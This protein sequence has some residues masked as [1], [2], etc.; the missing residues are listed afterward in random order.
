MQRSVRFATLLFVLPLVALGLAGTAHAAIM[1][2]TSTVTATWDN[3]TTAN[4]ATVSGG[5]YT[6]AWAS[7]SDAKFEGPAGTV[8]VS[9]TITYVNSIV[10]ATD[11]YLLAGGTVTM[12]GTGGN[13]TTGAGADTIGSVIAGTVGLTKAGAGTLTLSGANS[14]TGAVKVSA[15]TL[16]VTDPLASSNIL[17]QGGTFTGGSGTI[18][19]TLDPDPLKV[20]DR[21]TMTSG[22]LDLS[23][24]TIDFAGAAAPPTGAAYVLVDY[25]A[26]GVLTTATNPLSDDT[27]FAATNV[28]A[29][30]SFEYDTVKK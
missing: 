5:P 9:G 28:P 11:G 1:Y 27:S 15:G 4:W 24:F 7:N 10:F 12:T 19:F 20:T 16:K 6:S 18:T 17:V 30:Y 22:T 8:T 29:G 21:I 25:S 13:I 14:F 26:G 3:G 2:G 23:T